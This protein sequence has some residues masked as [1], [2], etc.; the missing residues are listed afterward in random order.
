[1]RS[2]VI[3]HLM[4]YSKAREFARENRKEPTRAEKWVW[5]FVRNRRFHGLKFN[6]Q[7]V[8][9]YQPGAFYIA[10]FHCHEHKLIIELDGPIHQFTQEADRIRDEILNQMG[11]KVLRF[12]NDEILNEWNK[13]QERML[14]EIGL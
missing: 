14:M 2:S 8:I 10:D 3:L 6:R 9:E 11:F 7:Y 13:V 1:M 4:K 5:F 12:R